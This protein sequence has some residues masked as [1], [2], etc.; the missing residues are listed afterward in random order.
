MIQ[1]PEK[2][3]TRG[4]GDIADVP[5][6]LE[7][8][9]V[10]DRAEPPAR[11]FFGPPAPEPVRRTRAPAPPAVAAPAVEPPAV[12]EVVDARRLAAEVDRLDRARS[13]LKRGDTAA[14]SLLLAKHRR[15]F[16]SDGALLAESQ[17]LEVRILLRS[18]RR[19]EAAVLAAHS[20]SDSR[21]HHWCR[22]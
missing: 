3:G 6:I 2:A 18:G 1:P 14:A 19:A 9:A 13:H 8:P 5:E 22:G 20:S 11:G 15:E 16:A 7:F 12:T 17:F 10:A 4:R 21:A